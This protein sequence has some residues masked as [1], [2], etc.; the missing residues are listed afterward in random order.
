MY[1]KLFGFVLLFLLFI[2][3]GCT[4]NPNYPPIS[5]Q[6]QPLS[7]SHVGIAVLENNISIQNNID[8]GVFQSITQGSTECVGFAGF[9]TYGMLIAPFCMSINVPIEILQGS[10]TSENLEILKQEK[11]TVQANLKSIELQ[12]ELQ[13]KA[14]EYA[15]KH[16]INVS[17]IEQSTNSNK[18]KSNDYSSLFSKGI[19]TVVEYEIVEITFE[20]A[21]VENLPIYMTLKVKSRLIQTNDGHIIEQFEKKVESNIHPYQEWIS[22]DFKLLT[23]EYLRLLNIVVSNSIDEFLFLYY[24][25]L[26]KNMTLDTSKREAPYYVL[27]A[28]NPK[29]IFAT[30]DMRV[31]SHPE[32]YQTVRYSQRRFVPIYD[33]K[34]LFQ[35]ESFPWKHDLISKERFS[36]IVYDLEIYKYEEFHQGL[37][38]HH[39]YIGKLVYAKNGL[40]KNEHKLEE[41]LE[42]NTK[43]LWSVRARFKLD[44]KTRLTEWGG[45]YYGDQHAWSFGQERGCPSFWECYIDFE[46]LNNK[47]NYYYP[48]IILQK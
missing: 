10:I 13:D 2:F 39:G 17:R 24:P 45:L 34:P 47:K 35:W 48:V 41:P 3:S 21:D 33:K 20:E 29:P 23:D 37:F 9:G 43:Y 40:T 14:L 46:P 7:Y 31:F 44:G 15:H 1:N 18:D 26:S 11:G 5:R 38:L 6:K 16:M 42:E 30:P 27:L 4:Y 19:D 8:E 12:R 25:M 28:T 32:Q 22:N 36:E